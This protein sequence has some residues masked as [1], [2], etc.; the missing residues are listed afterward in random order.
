MK[1]SSWSLEN[2]RSNKISKCIYCVKQLVPVRADK[3]PV[4][5]KQTG[6]PIVSEMHLKNAFQNFSCKTKFWMILSPLFLGHTNV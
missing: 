1:P 3:Y 5:P 2:I 4:G 6:F